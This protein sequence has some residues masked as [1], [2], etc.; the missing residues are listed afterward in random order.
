MLGLILFSLILGACAAPTPTV[1]VTQAPVVPTETPVPVVKIVVATDAT[2]PPF[3]IVDDATKELTG[4]DIELM[5]AVAQKGG[6]EVEF[7]NIA[8]DPM[9]A[10]L[11]ECQ[12]DAS[13]AA[14]TITDDRKAVMLFSDPYINAGQIVAVRTDEAVIKGKDDLAGK[15][16]GVQLGTTGAIE[17]GKIDGA[18]IKTYD[19]YDLAFLDLQNGQVD[20]V[21]A[22][23]PTALNFVGKASDKLMVTGEVFTDESY[24]I[25]V[26]KTKPELVTMINA[27]LAAAKAD[28]TITQLEQKWLAGQ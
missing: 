15:T 23:Y 13:I 21:I 26:C 24:G 3:E 22:D 14:I 27:G 16:I 7:V 17:A 19:A 12:Y 8:F 4:F 6:F 20:A 25:A 9:L 18:V 1:V 10:G 5:K 2:F 28:G 11:S